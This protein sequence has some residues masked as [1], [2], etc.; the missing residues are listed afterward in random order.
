M[1]V[2]PK[3]QLPTIHQLK[4]LFET[5]G[6]ASLIYVFKSAC[7]MMLQACHLSSVKP[8]VSLD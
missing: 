7:Y 5:F 3:A 6:P 8:D 2:R 4:E 1:Q